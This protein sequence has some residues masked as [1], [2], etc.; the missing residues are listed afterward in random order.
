ME[1]F[2]S[3]HKFLLHQSIPNETPFKVLNLAHKYK[4]MVGVTDRGNSP[5]AAVR[6]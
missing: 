3:N 2:G 5:S 6:N 1:S 4:T